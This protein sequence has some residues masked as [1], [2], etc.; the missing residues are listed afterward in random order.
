M[1]GGGGGVIL[2][3]KATNL[4]IVFIYEKQ[5]LKFSVFFF[6]MTNYVIMLIKNDLKSMLVMSETSFF[7]FYSWSFFKLGLSASEVNLNL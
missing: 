2:P 5:R 7:F 6:N 1:G 4:T 3:G